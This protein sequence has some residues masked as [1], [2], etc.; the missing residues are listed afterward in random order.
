[1]IKHLISIFRSRTE[2]L[3]WLQ[4]PLTLIT[5]WALMQNYPIYYW[6]AS[7]LMYVAIGCLGISIMYHRY[8]THKSFEFKPY[9]K[10]LE[11]PFSILGALAGTGSTIGW[12]AVHKQHHRYSDRRGDP[13]S[14][15][16]LGWKTL[17]TRYDFEWNK[18]PIRDLI[19]NK[20]HRLLHEYYYLWLSLI[21][22]VLYLISPII[23]L[24]GLLIP[25]CIAIWMSTVS[26]YVNH[27]YGYINFKTPELSK[28]NWIMAILTFGEGW[29]NNH[30]AK[31]KSYS[32]SYKK[33]EVDLSGLMI[34]YLLASVRN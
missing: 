7:L 24:F 13:H 33:H 21:A 18:W 11:Y 9:L 6:I 29:H 17:F 32:F 27:K 4:I 31:S 25:A 20:F 34:K 12:V 28:N 19:T 16:V 26:N 2:I 15:E 22:L 10:W 3:V 30:H 23:L 8:L 5:I 14:P 1:M